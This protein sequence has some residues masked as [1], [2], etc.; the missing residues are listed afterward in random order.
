M[1]PVSF[2]EAA[3][4]SYLARRK[5]LSSAELRAFT[6]GLR[7]EALKLAKS[8]PRTGSASGSRSRVIKTYKTQKATTSRP[9]VAVTKNKVKAA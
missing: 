4:L 7:G 5:S 8:L 6:S 1:T 9:R 3:I 2:K